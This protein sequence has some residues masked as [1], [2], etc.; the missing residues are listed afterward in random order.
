MQPNNTQRVTMK[1][2]HVDT[3]KHSIELRIELLQ[4]LIEENIESVNQGNTI[5]SSES[6]VLTGP[7]LNVI[8]NAQHEILQLTESLAWLESDVAGICQQ[9]GAKISLHRLK[10]SPTSRL[11][12]QCTLQATQE[13]TLQ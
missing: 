11:C 4:T 3:V 8:E 2:Q 1:N 7:E 10:T 12:Q 9:C 13:Q 6:E 5:P